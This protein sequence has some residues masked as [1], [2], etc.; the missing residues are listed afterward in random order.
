MCRSRGSAM[1]TLPECWTRV[2]DGE[3]RAI[4]KRRSRRRVSL[5]KFDQLL[6]AVVSGHW[7]AKCRP[8]K[9][10][11][12]I[13]SARYDKVWHLETML[14]QHPNPPWILHR[15]STKAKT[16][17]SINSARTPPKLHHHIATRLIPVNSISH[18]RIRCSLGPSVIVVRVIALSH[19]ELS[20]SVSHLDKI[21]DQ[22]PLVSTVEIKLVLTTS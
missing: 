4:N 11:W 20:I 16:S 2:C 8:S 15:S 18:F 10:P 14:Y 6:M 12:S 19:L 1:Q 7:K 5:L 17:T 22:I 3:A 21:L 9:I 13:S